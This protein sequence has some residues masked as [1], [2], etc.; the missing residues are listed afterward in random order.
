[1]DLKMEVYSPFLELLGVLEVFNSVIWE[2]KAFSTGSFS[3]ESLITDESKTLL[4][5]ENI[6]WIEGETAGIIE[7]F[8]EETGPSGP[9]ISVKG[10]LLTGILERC[11]LWGQYDMSGTPPI[12][13]HRLVNDCCVNP[14]RGDTEAR[15]IPHLV[16]LGPPAGG[17]TIRAQ[18]TGGTLLEALEELGEAYGVAFGIRFNPA[19]PR[20]EFWTRWGQNRGVNQVA[21]DPV[22]YST[23]L[24]DV[25]SSEYS[26]NSQDWKNVALVAGEGEGADRKMVVVEA[27]AEPAPEPPVPSTK[28]TITLSVDPD[29]GG[30]ASG[31]G[32]V[33]EGQSVTVTAV[34]SSGYAFAGWRENGAIVSTNASY[35]FPA[36]ADRSLTAVFA[37]VVP[38]YTITA[39]IDPEGSGTVTGA[40]Q[41]RE[42]AAV[43]LTAVMNDGYTFSG[44][45]ENGQTVSTDASYTFTAEA[46]RALAA[47]FAEVPA[48]R[49]PE[50]YTEIE[51]IQFI[52]KQSMRIDTGIKPDVSKTKIG[53]KWHIDSLPATSNNQDYFFAGNMSVGLYYLALTSAGKIVYRFQSATGGAITRNPSS[54][55]ADR[56]I[57]FLVDYPRK[58]LTFDGTDYSMGTVNAP[59]GNCFVVYSYSGGYVVEG[60]L[61]Y[62]KMYEGTDLVADLV[63]CINS[64]G[65]V[66]LYDIIGDTF[67]TNSSGTITPGP[68]V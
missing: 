26:Y 47:V 34:P 67:L 56:D 44:W 6:I 65:V 48:S 11:I 4:A 38:T 32:Q 24:D 58:K 50:G 42:D 35:T 8:H 10:R 27:G 64:S 66:G 25:L 16:L 3:L 46:N 45:Q 40:G 59:S 29:G 61:Y 62:F 60:K 7:Y 5:P 1:M 21:N 13:M 17:S 51:Y 37:V 43:T 15:K 9:Y 41:Y 19:V 55:V 14:A 49:L 68:A 52:G 31:S 28:Y 20:M 53:A 57:E 22:F 2:E 12:I 39:T 54:S 30:T 36:S 23:E 33:S 63:P 18:K